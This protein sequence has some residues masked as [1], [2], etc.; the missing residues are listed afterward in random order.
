METLPDIFPFQQRHD[1]L[2]VLLDDRRDFEQAADRVRRLMFIEKLL[3]EIDD[4]MV[5]CEE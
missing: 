3:I 1:E 2:A 4:A 5:A